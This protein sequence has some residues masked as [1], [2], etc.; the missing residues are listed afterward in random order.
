MPS[1][2]I[3]KLPERYNKVL[4]RKTNLTKQGNRKCGKTEF[5]IVYIFRINIDFQFSK[6]KA[7]SSTKT[8]EY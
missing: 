4:L 5:V 7:T 1:H 6:N 2:H 3:N 8:Q